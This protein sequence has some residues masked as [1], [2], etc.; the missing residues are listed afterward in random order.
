MAPPRLGAVT[1]FL[2]VA[3]LL[4]LLDRVLETSS[5]DAQNA[6][7]SVLSWKPIRG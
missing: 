1:F 4:Y 7:L 2:T 6:S 5:R 3:L